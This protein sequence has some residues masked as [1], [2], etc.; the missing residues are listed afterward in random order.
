[1]K[2]ILLALDDGDVT[3]QRFGDCPSSKTVGTQLKT[4][5][6]QGEKV[7]IMLYEHKRTVRR[8]LLLVKS[9]LIQAVWA[10]CISR[11]VLLLL[12]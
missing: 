10:V 9:S 1:M 8:L 6:K 5:M 2:L 4:K 11:N 12:F 3:K 7:A